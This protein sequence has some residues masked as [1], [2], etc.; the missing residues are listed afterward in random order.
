MNMKTDCAETHNDS[1][2]LQCHVC[3]P[4]YNRWRRKRAQ[5]LQ[6][7][8]CVMGQASSARSLSDAALPYTAS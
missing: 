3:K 4:A 2:V 5:R 8:L 6:H 7:R 1:T